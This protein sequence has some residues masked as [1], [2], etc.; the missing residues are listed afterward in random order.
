MNKVK[1]LYPRCGEY[2]TVSFTVG[3]IKSKSTL[4]LECP[5]CRK[6]SI[7]NRYNL[8]VINIVKGEGFVDDQYQTVQSH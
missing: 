4:E 5:F 8:K 2:F 1:C 6:T 3:Q 7:F